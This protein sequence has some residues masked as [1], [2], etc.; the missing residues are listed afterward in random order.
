MHCFGEDGQPASAPATSLSARQ[1]ACLP[2]QPSSQATNQPPRRT[3]H[4]AML[5]VPSTR[6][7]DF[8]F[9]RR[10][11]GPIFSHAWSAS[12]TAYTISVSFYFIYTFLTLTLSGL[13]FPFT[14]AAAVVSFMVVYS[15][16][17]VMSLSLD[18]FSPH[19]II[20]SPATTPHRLHRHLHH[21]HHH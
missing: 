1:P 10:C 16:Y 15:F 20:L 18:G 2:R 12:P 8:P 13:V 7:S 11:H 4:L 14:D 5:C 9:Y 17:Q 19:G 21:S 6:T 3:A